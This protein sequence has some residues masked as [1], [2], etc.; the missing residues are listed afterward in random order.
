MKYLLSL[1]YNKILWIPIFSDQNE[2]TI[3]AAAAGS[4]NAV[5]E[6]VDNAE[7]EIKT[8]M[9]DESAPISVSGEDPLGPVEGEGKFR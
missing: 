1:L 3:P 7:E 2:A 8:I 5:I 9:V 4:G 6:E